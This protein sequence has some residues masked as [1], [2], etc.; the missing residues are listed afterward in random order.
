MPFTGF[1]SRGQLNTTT[2]DTLMLSLATIQTFLQKTSS[3][4]V[5]T[6]ELPFE[7]MSISE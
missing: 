2:L 7:G 6:E 1:T 5:Q 3:L 4:M